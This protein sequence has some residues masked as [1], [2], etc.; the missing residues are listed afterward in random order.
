LFLVDRDFA[1]EHER[2]RGQLR[3]G[4]RDVG[5]APGVLHTVPADEADAVAFLV[6]DDAPPVDLLLVDPAGAVERLAD[7]CGAHR[8]VV[9]DHRRRL[10]P[11]GQVGTVTRSIR[12]PLEHAIHTRSGSPGRGVVIADVHWF[13]AA[14]SRR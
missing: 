2:S 8:R 10:S 12:A 14:P 1:I 5:E 3:G 13:K 11:Y 4:R 7:A 6:R 9:G